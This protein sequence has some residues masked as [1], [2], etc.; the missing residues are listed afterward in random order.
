[1]T[2]N[3]LASADSVLIPTL[4]QITDVRGLLMFLDTIDQIRTEINPSL[5]ILGVVLNLFNG[6]LNHHLSVQQELAN[7][8]TV[9][10]IQ[11]GRSIRVAEAGIEGEP[12]RLY[13]P[14]N[15]QLSTYR[16]LALWLKNAVK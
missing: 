10:P 15:K 7:V 16:E 8:T 14:R 2:V 6:R 1:M 12:L 5:S 4:P 3:A 13:D 11:I 9:A